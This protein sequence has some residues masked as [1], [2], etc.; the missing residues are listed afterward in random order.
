MYY[1]EGYKEKDIDV[2]SAVPIAGSAPSGDRVKVRELPGVEQMAC[3]TLQGS[4]EGLDEAY[5]RLILWIEAH[6]YHIAGP[7]R[8]LYIKGPGLLTRPSGYVTELQIPVE[9]A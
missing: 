9:K 8:E 5:G 6:G 4:Y 7:S 2:E 3:L 1:D